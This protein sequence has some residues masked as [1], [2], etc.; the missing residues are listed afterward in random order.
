MSTST[1]C[2][3]SISEQLE[4]KNQHSFLGNADSDPSQTTQKPGAAPQNFNVIPLA[5][6]KK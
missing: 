2:Q 6:P 4:N 1:N 5:L 3:F